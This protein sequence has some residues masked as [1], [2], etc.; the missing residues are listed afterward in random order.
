MG[1]NN[2]WKRKRREEKNENEEV[3]AGRPE[4]GRQEDLTGRQT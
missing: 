1:V 2:S 3:R 4:K